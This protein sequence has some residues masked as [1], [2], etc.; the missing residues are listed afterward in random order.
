MM[1]ILIEYNSTYTIKS[2]I[3]HIVFSPQRKW[4][5][6][7]CPMTN[8]RR[9]RSP[10]SPDKAHN[11]SRRKAQQGGAMLRA[12]DDRIRESAGCSRARTAQRQR[13]E[14][15][16]QQQQPVKMPH[17]LN[18]F[19]SWARGPRLSIQAAHT[20]QHHRVGRFQCQSIGAVN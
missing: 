20:Q 8:E 17:F 15:E 2:S 14:P 6:L 13:H 19:R 16:I 7:Q 10:G 3:G 1:K 12:K 9:S 4:S 18:I 11:R 5:P